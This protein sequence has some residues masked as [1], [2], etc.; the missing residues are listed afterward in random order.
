MQECTI[1][2][3]G[4]CHRGLRGTIADWPMGPVIHPGAARVGCTRSILIGSMAHIPHGEATA[5]KRLV[6]RKQPPTRQKHV[7]FANQS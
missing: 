4:A 3:G 5:E 2:W 7:P 1:P 6:C